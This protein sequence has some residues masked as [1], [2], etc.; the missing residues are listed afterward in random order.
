MKILNIL[1]SV[2]TISLSSLN[3][4]SQAPAIIPAEYPGLVGLWTFDNST[5]LLEATVGNNLVLNGTHQSIQGPS[6]DDLA[7]S[8]GE[9]DYY[10]CYHDIDGNG[11]GSEVN[12][13]SLVIDFRIPQANQWYCFYQ[14]NSGNSNDGELFI[15]PSSNVGRSTNGPGYSSYQIVPNEWYRMVVSVDLGNYYRVYL[16]GALVLDGDALSIDGEYSLYPS[17]GQNLFHYFL[18]N[19]GEDNNIDIALAG[20]FNYSVNSDVAESLGGYGHNIQPVL[21]GILPYLQTPTPNSIYIS[22]HSDN[23]G[24]SAV[25]YGTSSS[26]GLSQT[27]SVEDISGNK[28]HTVKLSNLTPDTEYFYKCISEGEES[29]IYK[30]KTHEQGLP[31]DGKFRFILLGDS[32]TD[33]AK[34]TEIAYK[35]KLKAQEMFGGDI[36]NQIKLLV[37]VGDIVSTGSVIS[38]YKNEY[39]TPYAGLSRHI[40]FMV[41]IGN[42]EGESA[43]YYD[44]MK[45]EDFSDYGSLLNERFYSFTLNNI[46]FIMMNSNTLLQNGVQTNWV[47][48]KLMQSANN[49]DIDIVLC[50]LHHPGRSELWPDGNTDY[51]QNDIIPLL[52]N[53]PKV[54]LLSYG[55]SHNYERGVIESTAENTNGDFHIMLTGG[56]GSALDRWG[57]YPNQEDYPEILMTYDHYVFNIVDIDLFEKTMDVYTYSLGHLDKTLDCV[58]IDKYHRKLLQVNPETPICLS[59]NSTTGQNPLLV[60]SNFEGEDSLMTSHFQLTTISGD[61]SA[62]VAES[63]RD[64]VNIY[65]DTGP[66]DYY[67][68]DLNEGIDLKRYQVSQELNNGST[69]YWRVRYRDHNLKW[70]NWSEEQSFTVSANTTNYT[71]FTAN[72]TEGI[73]PL[74]VNFTDLS[75][76]AVNTWEWDL[77]VDG[78]TDSEEQD[79]A[80]TY[81]Q[82]GIYSVSLTTEHGTETKDLYINTETNEINEIKNNNNDIVRI[83]PNP[84]YTQTNIEFVI[85]EPEQVQIRIINIEGKEIRL[86]EHAPYNKGKHYITWNGCDSN[87]AKV[88]PGKYFVKF[89]AGNIKEIKSVIIPEK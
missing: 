29:D 46:Q 16:D 9:G 34:T 48:E 88:S 45:Y 58:L 73:V 72:I 60:A 65:G 68:I 56:A 51:V 83:H 40:P 63:K 74:T 62:L 12:E 18:D 8:I 59:P 31:D 75:Y 85:D 36:Q 26:L 87:G 3:C 15:N 17:D 70:S 32:R 19:N 30:F 37:H 2:A 61:Y 64:W 5:Q 21:T 44:Y 80:F 28:W 81:N 39:F 78:D 6:D 52:A 13:Y 47:E 7:I 54:Q 27:G 43:N 86:L 38:Q 42:H 11:G 55:H 82:E 76:P 4:Y 50:F 1:I 69:Y 33:A 20:L 89:K 35:A 24:S 41:T 22:W 23:T 14:T 77:D 10:T 66:P 84:F 79:P 67:A 57:M 53:Y 71:D 25:E 49:D